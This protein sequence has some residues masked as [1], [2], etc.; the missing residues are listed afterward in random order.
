VKEEEMDRACTSSMHGKEWNAYR[1]L[2][3]KLGGK[4]P[5][6]RPARR[7]ENN[8]KI[9]LRGIGRSSMGWINLAQ[10]RCQWTAFVNIVM[11]LRVP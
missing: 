5:L 11:N 9:D 6:G 4:R 2:E 1:I 10:D 8:I 3:G 7:W